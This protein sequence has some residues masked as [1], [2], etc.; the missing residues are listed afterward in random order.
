MAASAAKAAIAA[1]KIGRV[2]TAVDKIAAA[3]IAVDKGVVK[4]AIK[5]HTL[6]NLLATNLNL[7]TA[8]TKWMSSK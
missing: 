5:S 8:H 1:P 6:H 7:S 3:V 2:E 4:A